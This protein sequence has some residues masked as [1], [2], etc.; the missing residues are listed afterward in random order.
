MKEE[1]GL[2]ASSLQLVMQFD[3]PFTY[4][5]ATW[6]HKGQT[7]DWLLYYWRE[8]DVSKCDLTNEGV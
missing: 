2:D 8:A 1:V 3:H 6:T 4:E 7:M 5:H